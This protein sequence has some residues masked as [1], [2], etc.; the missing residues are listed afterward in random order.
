MRNFFANFFFCCLI[1]I[2]SGASSP[3]TEKMGF[4]E[5]FVFN[6][7]PHDQKIICEI[8]STVGSTSTGLLLFKKSHL[9]ELGKKTNHIPP[10]QFLAYVFSK[11]DLVRQMEKIRSS[12]TKY[13][14]F[15]AGFKAGLYHQ[16]QVECLGTQVEGFANYLSLNSDEVIA[17]LRISI[18]NCKEGVKD[19]CFRPFFDYLIDQKK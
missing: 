2:L 5:P 17:S 8:V 18:K 15:I 19:S 10:L 6:V 13:K 3:K 9:E 12:G 16:Y 1:A 11:P 4:C 7:T 14:H